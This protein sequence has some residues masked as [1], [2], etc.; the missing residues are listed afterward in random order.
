MHYTVLAM[1]LEYMLTDV[2]DVLKALQMHL[3]QNVAIGNDLVAQDSR[4]ITQFSFA[5]GIQVAGCQQASQKA[6]R[7][8]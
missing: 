8:L 1:L 4:S 6:G 7:L 5:S 2:S 3:P